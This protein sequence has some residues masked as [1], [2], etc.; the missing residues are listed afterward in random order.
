MTEKLASHAIV[1][2]KMIRRLE[3]QIF[4]VLTIE[5]QDTLQILQDKILLQIMKIEEGKEYENN[6][7]STRA[8]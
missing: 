3:E 8:V 4:G 1:L 7:K 6:I 5:E 2:Q